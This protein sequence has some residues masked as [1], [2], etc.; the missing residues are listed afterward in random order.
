MYTPQAWAPVRDKV[1]AYSGLERGASALRRLLVGFAETVEIDAA[2]RV[3]VSPELRKY[4]GLNK[5]V[6]LIGQGNYLELWDQA[7][8][9]KQIADVSAAGANLVPP[10]ME[11]FSL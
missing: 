11:G 6:M 9:D 10:G 3:L 4:A 7:A 2:G 8:W 5:E 1:V